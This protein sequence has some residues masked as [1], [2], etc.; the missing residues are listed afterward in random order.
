MLRLATV[1]GMTV[2][3]ELAKAAPSRETAL[4]IGTFD[5]VH[6]GHQRLLRHLNAMAASQGLQSMVLTFRNHPRL[7]LN[8]GA[9]LDY[10]TSLEDRIATL[11]GQGIGQVVCID[12]TREL[13]LLEASEFVSLL[14]RYLRM[15]GMVVGP[16]FALGHHREGDI[17]TLRRLGAELGFW[18]EPVEPVL[19][20]KM[21]IRSSVI[22]GLIAGGDVGGAGRM[23]G[24]WYSLTGRVVEGDH[25]GHLLGFP[26][27]NLSLEPGLVTPED[28]IYATWAT[29]DGCR[30]EAATS[31]GVRPTFGQSRRT[32]EAFIMDFEGDIY[33]KPLAL[34]FAA[35]LREE[36]A[37]PN[38]ESLIEQMKLDVEQARAVLARATG[39]GP[40]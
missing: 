2:H 11:Q 32:V 16:G 14:S 5:G 18:V 25:R 30:H 28:G 35:R 13:S 12:F 39:D 29:V 34:E 31:I 4:T 7:V 20:D 1:A 19:S 17:P 22:R 24:R 21:V 9:E 27:A 23:L 6:L 40:R 10:I 36:R 3:Q 15:K 26:T 37:F 38:S 33:G 8:P